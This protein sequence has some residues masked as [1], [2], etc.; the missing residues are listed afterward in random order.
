[1]ET[2]RIRKSVCV[3]WVGL[4]V[5]LTAAG[6]SRVAVGANASEVPSVLDR[7]QREDDPELSELI[8]V[9]VAN[10]KNVANVSEQEVL[11]L[12]RK[13]TQSYAQIKLLDQQIEQ[14]AQ[15]IKVTRGLAEMQSEL[16]LA[17]AE[18]ESKRTT[19]LASLRELMGIVPKFPF[20]IQPVPTLNAFV[21]ILPIDE[22]A[23]VLDALKPFSDYWAM[24]RHTVAGLLSEQ[25]TLDYVRDRLRDK[26]SLPLRVDIYHKA[27]TDNMCIRLRDAIFALA[28]E[29]HAEMRTEVRL[30][31]NAW[32]GSGTATFFLREGRIRTLYP[33]PLRRPD[34]GSKLL[35]SGLVD[36]NDLEQHI[37]WRLTKP[38]N[39]PVKL[40]IEYDEAST[41]LA[42]QVAKTAQ[43][44]AKRLGIAEL[45]EVASVLAEPVPEVMFLG[46]WE[47]LGKSY[48]QTIDVRTEGVCQV[49]MGDGSQAIKAGTSVKG[50][51]LPTTREI[52]VDI[53]DR[54]PGKPP[55]F[56]LGHFNE[57]GNLVI[58]RTEIYSQGSLSFAGV[59]QTVFKKV[60]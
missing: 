59:G 36:P 16:L 3:A 57:K 42:K 5:V 33:Q 31:R 2:R 56:Y 24:E 29:A 17:K 10:R 50:T 8:R 14:V 23:L 51:W 28:R 19:E 38:K 58:D 45:V 46:R 15:K 44:M 40:Q 30:L 55:Y 39:V 37:L 60:Q 49:L 11:D 25:G 41:K 52:L 27:E 35:V 21:S 7:V 13:V 34:G 26:G 1:M 18:L 32:A 4:S 20:E 22:R 9:A 43:T 53:N 6:T 48:I 47:A 12:V 54:V